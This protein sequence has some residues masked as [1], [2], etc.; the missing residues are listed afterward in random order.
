MASVNA[1]AW[2]S[3]AAVAIAMGL[4][5]FVPAW[6]IHYWHGW[7]YLVIFM[8]ASGIITLYLM[9]HNPALLEQRLKGG[10][11][12]ERR[13]V[14]KFVMAWASVGFI[15]LLVIPALDFRFEWSAVPV[16]IVIAGDLLVMIGF[17]F[18]FRV[19]RENP[20]L[21]ATI[22]IKEG[23]ELISTGSY[24]FVR[25]PMYASALL[26]LIGTPLA[27]GSYWGLVGLGVM[28]PFL[29]WR[30]LDEERFLSQNLPGYVEYRKRVRYHLVPFVW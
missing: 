23:Q 29:L 1:K 4:L 20:Y 19:Y 10:P 26:Y 24:A 28:A 22:Q 25:H 9:R 6:S 14:Q 12:A 7:V 30:L 13:P 18:M 17:Y 3:L 16:V 11:T 8:G 15:S 27:L 5:L 21:W 2:S